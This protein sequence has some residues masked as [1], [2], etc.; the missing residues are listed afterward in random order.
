MKS[1]KS[2]IPDT[3]KK[4]IQ[5]ASAGIQKNLHKLRELVLEVASDPDI[6]GVEETLKWNAPSF[7]A[8]SGKGTT[9]RLEHKESSF[10]L[11]AHC[12]SRVV[13]RFRTAGHPDFEFDGTRGLQF[14]ATETLK[15]KDR[16]QGIKDFIRL[17]LTYH[18]WK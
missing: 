2:E 7:I 6:G 3:T 4:S 11:R 8:R 1:L 10:F 13:D 14:S 9:L 18:S 12:Q 17:A 5:E 16:I 15:G